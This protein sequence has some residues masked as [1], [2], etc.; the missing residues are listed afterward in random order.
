MENSTKAIIIAA[1][2]VITLAIVTVGFLI[3]K[4]GTDI[5]SG[6]AKDLDVQAR[7]IA[8]KKYTN[9]EDN[10]VSGSQ[11]LDAIKQF[12]T[13]YI[14]IQVITKK[15]TS[16]TWYLHD[17]SISSDV[18]EVGSEVTFDLTDAK[19]ET[20][21]EYINPAGR[22]TGKIIRDVNDKICAIIFEQK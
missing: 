22:F 4:S 13:D 1:S 6:S 3:L 17:V 21:D 11:V 2:I 7:A 10:D 8:E 15:D 9:Y 5:A 19:D 16:G 20:A 14:G 12:R 18:G